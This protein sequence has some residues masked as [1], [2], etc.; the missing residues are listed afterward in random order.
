MGQIMQNFNFEGPRGARDLP[1]VLGEMLTPHSIRVQMPRGVA[2]SFSHARLG[3]VALSALSIPGAS[4]VSCELTDSC[5]IVFVQRGNL[6]YEIGNQSFQSGAGQCVIINEGECFHRR[7]DAQGADLIILKIKQSQL[8]RHLLGVCPGEDSFPRIC[9]PTRFDLAD[10][11]GSTLWR[12]V[13]YVWT[14]LGSMDATLNVLDR[15]IQNLEEFLVKTV[16]DTAAH[17]SVL[18]ADRR[19][20]QVLPSYMKK[21]LAYMYSHCRESIKLADL[22]KVGGISERSVTSG[23][24]RYMNASPKQYLKNLRLRQVRDELRHASGR[25]TVTEVAENWGF[26]QLGWFSAEYRKL[27][28]EQPSQTLRSGTSITAPPKRLT[29]QQNAH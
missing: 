29:S 5:F 14:E 23:F 4:E 16:L 8:Q 15:H 25:T 28:G 12:C 1:S 26:N 7:N 11:L 18:T 13:N 6:V 17:D 27:F 3:D 22:C 2:T 10:P 21:M 19:E 24:R 9:L 20:R